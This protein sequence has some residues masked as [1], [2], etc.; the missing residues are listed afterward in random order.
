LLRGAR[1]GTD[2]P[3]L[4]EFFR[5]RGPPEDEAARFVD[6]TL[7]LLEFCLK[8]G[9]SEAAR[10]RVDE[11]VGKLGSRSYRLRESA[12]TELIKLGLAARPALSR[13]VKHTDKEIAW[14]AQ[15]CLDVIDRAHSIEVEAAAVRLLGVRRPDGACRVLLDYLSSVRH[16]TVEEEALNALLAVGI[17]GGKADN[18]LVRALDDKDPSRRAAAALVL[19]HS[20]TAALREKVSG[21]L[22]TEADPKVRLRGAQGLLAARDKR[23]VPVLVQLVSDASALVAREAHE[24]LS[25]TASDVIPPSDL[26][27]GTEA[28][29]VRREVGYMVEGQRE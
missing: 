29:K 22:K 13:A 17:L 15:E 27:D 2:G 26:G 12:T 8:R 3:G 4:L 24:V 23:A 21:L 6:A 16:A 14:R 5:K 20:G 9:P 19:G 28:R 10:Q 11:L 7:N 18:A 1:V 25:A